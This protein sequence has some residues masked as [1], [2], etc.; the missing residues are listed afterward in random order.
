[1]VDFKYLTF[2]AGFVLFCT[3]SFSFININIDGL[4][5][6]LKEYQQAQHIVVVI[7]NFNFLRNFQ[8]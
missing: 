1:M 6:S 7:P 3:I 8:K 5:K 4:I 2:L